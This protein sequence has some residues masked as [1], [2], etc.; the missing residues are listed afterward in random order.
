MKIEVWSDFACPFC[1]L[2]ETRLENA[3]KQV[4]GENFEIV[5]KSYQLDP[6]LDKK[7]T[8]NAVEYFKQR[9]G[10]NDEQVRAMFAQVTNAAKGDGLVYNMEKTV[11]TNTLD[12]HRL[13]KWAATFN[14]EKQLTTLL[15]KYYFTDGKDLA[16]HKVLLEAVKELK[17]DPIIAESVLGSN[18]FIDD[19]VGQIRQAGE[20][21]INSVPF[22]VIDREYGISGAQSTEYFV[23]AIKQIQKERQ[24]A[25]LKDIGA[26]NHG[27]SCDH[28]GCHH[29]HD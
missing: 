16:D 29:D 26:H 27:H 22:F 10:F 18:Q 20:F 23:E 11:M 1:Y 13:A 8:L 15:M 3:L 19:V 25:T 12:A 7:P 17:L 4:G 21:G 24:G 6:G 9:K 28:E 2:G 14:K 5:F